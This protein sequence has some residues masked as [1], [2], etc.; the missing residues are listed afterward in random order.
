M[1]QQTTANAREARGITE[2]AAGTTRTGVHSMERL[3]AAKERIKTSSDATAA[4]V[5]TIDEIAFQT[6]T[7]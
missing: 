4:I 6:K 3:S 5:K 1:S 7:G 2:A